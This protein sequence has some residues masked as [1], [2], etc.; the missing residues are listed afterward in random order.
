MYCADILTE[1]S[2]AACS[3]TCLQLPGATTP[4]HTPFW[5]RQRHNVT[6]ELFVFKREREEEAREREREVT[7]GE[8]RVSN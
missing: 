5:G 3:C 1:L 6:H 8:T 2:L 4:P 7:P